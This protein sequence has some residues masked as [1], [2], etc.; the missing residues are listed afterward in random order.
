MS[1][2]T[3]I[4]ALTAAALTNMVVVASTLQK[5]SIRS[6]FYVRNGSKMTQHTNARKNLLLQEL[7]ME[8]V[9]LKK[10]IS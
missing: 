4:A 5:P 6:L 3:G 9:L 8:E 10:I 7:L 1:T 2:P